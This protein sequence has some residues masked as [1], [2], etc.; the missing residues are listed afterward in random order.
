MKP[1]SRLLPA[2]L[3]FERDNGPRAN[4]QRLLT[5]VHQNVLIVLDPHML[6][7]PDNPSMATLVAESDVRARQFE[8]LQQ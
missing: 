1:V 7:K 2:P 4:D 5:L 6:F 8:L 3:D